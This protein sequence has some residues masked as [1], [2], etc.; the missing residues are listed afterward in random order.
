MLDVMLGI[1]APVDLLEVALEDFGGELDAVSG[2]VVAIAGGAG[3]GVVEVI[4]Q[5][6]ES[7]PRWL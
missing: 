4:Y 6:S 2:I 5:S 7:A 1:E 3:S